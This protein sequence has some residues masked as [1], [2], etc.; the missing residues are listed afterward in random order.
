M[1][2]K[3]IIITGGAG[4][5]GTNLIELLLNKTNFNLIS[6]DDYSSGSKINHIISPRLK[7]IKG[8]TL[9]IFKILNKYKK[10][11]DSVFHFGEFSRIYQ[12]FKMFN[13]CYLSNSIGSQTVFKF[14]LENKIRLIYSATSASIG[15]NGKDQNLSPYAYSKAKNLELLENLKTWFNF[16]F[17]VIYFYNVYGPKQISKG[18]MATVIGIF[19]NQYRKKKPLTIV[20]PGSQTRSFTHIEDTVNT[21]FLAWK[22]RKYKHYSISHKKSYSIQQV[23]KMFMSKVKY[24]PPRKGERYAS[25]LT[26]FSYNNKVTKKFGKIDLKDYITSFIKSAQN[27]EN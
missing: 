6:I 4:F 12:S 19:E 23:A 18:N 24:L 25:A 2:K 21:C 14:C 8:S 11:I 9:D 3:Y 7:Y 15:N 17:E 22:L 5:I 13:Q 26:S 27:Y 10:K 20:R 1:K 16:K